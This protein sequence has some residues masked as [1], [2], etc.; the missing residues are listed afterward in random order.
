MKPEVRNSLVAANAVAA[1]SKT[2]EYAAQLLK[3]APYAWALADEAYWL[4]RAAQEVA[5]NAADEL[6]PVAAEEDDS[7]IYAFQVAN[8]AIEKACTA[9]DELVS[10]AEANNH[11][12]RR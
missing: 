1:A 7:I 6:D 10:L 2:A 8:E 11:T 3:T 5:Q 12:I 9:A 4:C